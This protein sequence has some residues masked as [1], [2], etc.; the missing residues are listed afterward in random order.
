[1]L[2]LNCS[3]QPREHDK[4]YNHPIESFIVIY[5][6]VHLSHNTPNAFYF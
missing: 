3:I 6:G 1:M 2:F 5:V 4:F